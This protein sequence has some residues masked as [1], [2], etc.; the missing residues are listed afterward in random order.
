MINFNQLDS[1]ILI[2]S[3]RNPLTKKL[4]SLSTR[5]GRS[6]H[7][8]ILLEGTHLLEESLR[9]NYLPKEIIATNNW[10]KVHQSLLNK[11][12]ENIYI[13]KVTPEV[14]DFSL[15]TKNPD[16]VASVFPMNGLPKINKNPNFVLALDRLQDPGNMGSLFRTALAAEVEVLWLAL[17][18]DPLSP[19]V[20]RSSAGAVLHMPYLRF[21]SSED[22]ALEL[23]AEKL[24]NAAC[25][26]YQVVATVLPDSYEGDSAC[27]YWQLDWGKPTVLVLGNEGKGVHHLIKSI[28]KE[29]VTLP[30]SDA[31]ESLNVASVAVPMLLERRRAKMTSDMKI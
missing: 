28:C 13:R 9:T 27:P 2:S 26:G 8:A 23:F 14:L 30:H 15:S 11:L 24:E 19:K 12:P 21:G 16:G 10:L 20:L 31:V 7:Q 6:E 22:E 17:G 3:R 1:E 18:A 25:S 5:E 4:R 29:W